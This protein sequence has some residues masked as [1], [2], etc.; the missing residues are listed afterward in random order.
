M[1]SSD[2]TKLN[3]LSFEKIHSLSFFC[4][5]SVFVEVNMP[6]EDK[7]LKYFMENIVPICKE[8]EDFI[9]E[10]K[11]DYFDTMLALFS[12][13]STQI[14]RFDP[15][16]P[17]NTMLKNVVATNIVKKLEDLTRESN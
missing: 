10:N 2:E 1:L 13:S 8:I 4:F 16:H 15:T 12:I 9:V 14:E 17:I 7:E 5:V 11:F 3:D 6:E